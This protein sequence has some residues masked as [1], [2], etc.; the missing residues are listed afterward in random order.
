MLTKKKKENYANR[1]AIILLV[2]LVV[3]L[4]FYGLPDKVRQIEIKKVDLLADIRETDDENGLELTTEQEEV[5]IDEAAIAGAKVQKASAEAA[6]AAVSKDVV[7]FN[8]P[9]EEAMPAPQPDNSETKPDKRTDNTNTANNANNSDAQNQKD[10]TVSDNQESKTAKASNKDKD[11][12]DKSAANTNIEDFTTSRTGLRRFFAAL[13][14]IRNLGRPVRIAFLGDSFIEGDIV[15]A[16]FR[17]RMQERFGGRG[18]GFVP[19]ESVVAQYRPT[20]KQSAD[21]WKSYSIIKDKSRKYVLSGM[22]FEPKANVASISFQT[23]DMYSDLRE[24]S[25]LKFIYSE[26]ITTD[27][28]L[29]CEDETST[30]KLPATDKVTQYEIKGNFTKGA[31]TFNNAAGLKALGIALEDNQGVVVDNFSLRGNSG[32]VMSELDVESCRELQYIRPYD[33]I[34]LQY[35]LNVANE[36][37]LDYGWYRN[38]MVAVIEHIQDCFSGS[39]ILLLGV[40]DRSQKRGSGGYGTMPAVLSLLRAQRQTAKN[41]E[42]AF[43]SIFAAM[44]GQDSMVKYVNSNWASKDYTHLSFR[45]GREVANAL[46]DAIINEK[47]EYDSDERLVER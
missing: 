2:A 14:N 41:S 29:K 32:T 36:D 37:M 18:V 26:S 11:K 6:S 7:T 47:G 31:I 45:G 28:I 25:S 30:H 8:L 10:K 20:I 34:I 23:V 16:D 21:G 46:Y 15:V 22:V 17:A 39:D 35:G 40:S 19:V 43:W 42:V 24:V 1:F 5:A 38:R 27:L 12:D 4:L 33:L 44:G 13:N 9:K 3:N